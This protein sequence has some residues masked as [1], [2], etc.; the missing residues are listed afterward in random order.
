[1]RLGALHKRES[2]DPGVD[3]QLNAFVIAVI[4]S[5]GCYVVAQAEDRGEVF[6]YTFAKQSREVNRIQPHTQAAHT[7]LHQRSVMKPA[8][9][10][11]TVIQ[12]A[13]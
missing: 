3:S 11:A 13:R 2:K 6:R 8:Q 10:Q 12:F 1:M 5:V 9:Q 7:R 4:V